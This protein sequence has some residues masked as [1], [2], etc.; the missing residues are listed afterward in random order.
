MVHERGAMLRIRPPFQTAD[1]AARRLADLSTSR[2]SRRIGTIEAARSG[3]SIRLVQAQVVTNDWTAQPGSEASWQSRDLICRPRLLPDAFCDSW[4][5]WM[6]N[7]C[8]LNAPICAD[9][10]IRMSLVRASLPLSGPDHY[11]FECSRCQMLTDE[12]V[13]QIVEDQASTSSSA[14]ESGSSSCSRRTT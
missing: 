6:P 4:K 1:E 11:W 13:V 12:I 3:Q 8:L 10:D 7:S 9:C 14:I 2:R 5:V